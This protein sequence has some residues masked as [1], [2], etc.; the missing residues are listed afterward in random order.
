MAIKDNRIISA[1]NG[2]LF[3]TVAVLTICQI[4]YGMDMTTFSATQAMTAFETQFG[5]H[6]DEKTQRYTIEPYF[7]S[8]LNSLT[9]IGQIFGVI[10]G[11]YISRHYGR[12]WSLWTM[13]GWAFIA[14]ILLVTAQTKEQ[15]L[16]G[17]IINY[18][19]MGQELVTLPVMQSEIVPAHVRGFAVGTY[20]LGTMVG[21]SED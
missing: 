17:R 13:C 15:M 6:W 19:F 2:Q 21:H 18:V 9:Y 12:R 1:F 4:N 5:H 16:V 8:L 11:G 7:L 14:A 3:F 20:Q 10:M